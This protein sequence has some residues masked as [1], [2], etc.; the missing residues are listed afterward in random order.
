VSCTNDRRTAD[1]E[2][3]GKRSCL[4]RLMIRNN[5]H[6]KIDKKVVAL[7]HL[8]TR[9]EEVIILLKMSI[10]V[11]MCQHIRGN[12]NV[13]HLIMMNSSGYGRDC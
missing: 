10:I 6:K 1:E 4:F 11:L 2:I 9:L 13:A 8:N 7:P 3:S 12:E 5:K